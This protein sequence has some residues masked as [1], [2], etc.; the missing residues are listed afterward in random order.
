M[1][2][3]LMIREILLLISEFNIYIGIRVNETNKL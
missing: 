1:V 3:L 2:S